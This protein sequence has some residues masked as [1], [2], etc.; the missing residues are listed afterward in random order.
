MAEVIREIRSGARGVQAAESSVCREEDYHAWLL[1]QA[2]ALRF[3]RNGL[4]D[5]DGLAE[6]LE[7]MARSE[8]RGLA[9]FFLGLQTHLLKW[10]YQP[11]KRSGSWEASIQDSRDEITERLEPS[12]SLSA[13]AQALFDRAYP[14]ARRKAGAAMGMRQ[15]EW[16]KLLPDTPPW[17]LATARDLKFW[18]PPSRDTNGHN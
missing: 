9:S 6:E 13:K 16:E 11:E 15:Y 8:E 14:R 10:A 1:D 2:A 12:P 17:A 7:A 5:W 18:P 3:Q 4:I